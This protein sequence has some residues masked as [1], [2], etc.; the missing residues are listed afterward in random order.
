ML[1]QMAIQFCESVRRNAANDTLFLTPTHKQ[2]AKLNIQLNEDLGPELATYRLAV[3]QFIMY[4]GAKLVLS[5]SKLLT[6]HAISTLIEE[7]NE[8]KSKEIIKEIARYIR[9]ITYQS[10]QPIEAATIYAQV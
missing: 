2:L 7:I 5:S 4:P 3:L 1:S 8:G 6:R 10:T 9:T